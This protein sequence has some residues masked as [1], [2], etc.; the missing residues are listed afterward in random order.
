M[1]SL[2]CI[3]ISNREFQNIQVLLVRPEDKYANT[4][5]ASYK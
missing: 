5:A 2:I 3:V 4:A 1:S